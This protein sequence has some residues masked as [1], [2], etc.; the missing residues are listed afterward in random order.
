VLALGVPLPVIG[1]LDAGESRVTV[2]DDAEEVVR[3]AFVPVVRGV[4]LD[5]G[6]N[7][8]I[9][10]G[11]AHLDPH[12][13]VVGDRTQVVDRVQLG[14][15]VVRVVHAR[16]AERQLEAQGGVVAQVAQ[17]LDY[18]LAL[19]VDGQLAAVD[20]DTL[21]RV[22]QVVAEGPLQRVG[23][24][25]EV[26]SVGPGRGDLRRAPY[27]ETAVAGGVAAVGGTE[28]APADHRLLGETG[29]VGRAHDSAP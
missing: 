28:H 20:H 21:D 11:T 23:H 26:P 7:V 6:R 9:G 29:K 22:G 18:A 8:R 12:P 17:H 5:R 13:T 27:D 14:A 2:E 24:L 4:D 1:H 16:H 10:V 15:G 3:L 25:V 19:D